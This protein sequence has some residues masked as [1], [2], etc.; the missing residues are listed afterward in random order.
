MTELS[1]HIP[2]FYFLVAERFSSNDEVK[3][4]VQHWVKTLTADFFDERLQKLVPQY[5]K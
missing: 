4:A 1:T 2:H 5:D 3:T